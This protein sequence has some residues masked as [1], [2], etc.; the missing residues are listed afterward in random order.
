MTPPPKRPTLMHYV[1]RSDHP[2]QQRDSALPAA[3]EDPALA[4]AHQQ[5][6][7]Q[8]S[9]LVAKQRD[10]SAIV[11]ESVS[12]LIYGDKAVLLLFWDETWRPLMNLDGH[13]DA[14]DLLRAQTKLVELL[15]LMG[16]MKILSDQGATRGIQAVHNMVGFWYNLL[17]DRLG[18]DRLTIELTLSQPRANYSGSIRL[19]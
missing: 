5:A 2:S 4:L 11:G 9:A 18:V 3:E 16:S 12:P 10:F 1:A 19:H 7:R 6:F 14:G 8:R 17:A 13:M 15:R